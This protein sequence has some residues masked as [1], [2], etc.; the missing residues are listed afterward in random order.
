M[1]PDPFPDHGPDGEERDGSGP[2]PA[3]WSGPEDD[4]DGEAHLEALVASD[5]DEDQITPEWL[6]G[7]LT[8]EEISEVGFAQGMADAMGPGPVLTSLVCA[9]TRDPETLAGLADDDLI[10]IIS[11]TRRLECKA[12]WAGMAALR[13]FAA[14]RPARAGIAV[15]AGTAVS[16]FAADEVA[17]ALNL[18][19]LSA[20]GQI[21]Y[22][23]VVA[24][25][26]P[27]TFAALSAGR[28]HPVHV[29]IIV[30]ETSV[31]SD[32][33]AAQADEILAEAAHGKTFG[34]LRHAAH[35]LVLKLDP[36]SARRRKEQA[37]QDAHVRRFREDSGNGGIVARE[38]PADEV[39]ASWQHIEQ[40]A[41]DLR[42]AGVT[43]TL[44]ELRARAY[45]DLLQER[46]SRIAPGCSDTDQVGSSPEPASSDGPG[47]RHTDQASPHGP[48]GND[49]P[50]GPQG[51]SDPGG[52]GGSGP[53]PH[54]GPAGQGP[55]RRAGQDDGPSF[56]ALVT[57]T[58]PLGTAQGRSD[59]P[60]Q[61]DGFGLVDAQA[62]R[63][64][65]AAAARHPH[66][67]W[68]VTA[69]HPDGTAA[70]HGCAKGQ[71]RGP[72]GSNL[73][74]TRAT[75]DNRAGPDPP[76]GSRAPDLLGRLQVSLTPISRG[77]CDHASAESHYAPS[78]KLQH[79]VRARSA[80]CSAPGC[81]RPAARCDLDHTTAWDEGGLSCQC[82]LAPLCRHHHRC[83]QAEGWW[84]EQPEP[85]VLRWRAPSGRE[86][87]TTPTSYSA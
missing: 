72:P 62:A 61:A 7:G 29:K 14:R 54:R 78:R 8:A 13:E 22:A 82:N 35:I 84:L 67:R 60:A 51:G 27:R 80:R 5:G 50:D 44:R 58:V 46:D 2:Q 26:L 24:E 15:T 40:R 17:L 52:N 3:G 83:K 41:L 75:F 37:K 30:E 64:L 9:A 87:T 70:A 86:Y 77:G 32:E 71:L 23:C 59:E 53:G 16:E 81:G 18:T 12:A 73:D 28:I 66:T 74:P 1:S 39:L 31:L 20:A 42:A 49:R 76:P 34:Q 57:I 55:G 45:L 19:W 21:A 33:D 63:D 11:A 6:A 85:G 56:A 25:R 43:G 36:D 38:M 79:V 48:E 47:S 68:C 65:V 69:L 4:W 10:G